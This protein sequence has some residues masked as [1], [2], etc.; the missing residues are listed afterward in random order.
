MRN[1]AV[2]RSAVA[3]SVVSL[4][5][6][7]SACGGEG[8]SGDEG[9][10]TGKGKE[11]AAKALSAAELEKLALAQGDVEAHKVVK[12]GPQDDIAAKDVTAGKA[13]C[14][15][16]A[17]LL[18][19]VPVGEPGATVKRRVTSEPKKDD[20]AGKDLGDLTE[21]EIDDAMASALDVTTTLS[22]LASY[23]GKGAEDVVA[24][25]GTA[26]TACADGFTM[27]MAGTEQKV[28]KVGELKVSG[29]DEAVAWS[30]EAEQDGEK[31]SYA[32]AAVRHGGTVASFSS[33]NLVAL[34]DEKASAL[35]T[36]VI[37]AQ[38]AKLA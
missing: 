1:T 25:L 5:L 19:G 29:G 17:R 24:A 8:G 34:K 16:L 3:V 20:N 2:R 32:I 22:S 11:A 33:I 38:V 26:A 6:L 15:P 9:K 30:V 4:A 37:D 28:T 18:S 10:G 35:P 13:G 23:D 7:V 14:E 21:K 36:A 27:T 12:A 31:V